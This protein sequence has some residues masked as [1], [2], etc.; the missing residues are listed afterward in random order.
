MVQRWV[1]LLVLALPMRVTF[2]QGYAPDEA[3]KR[4]AVADGLEVTL[5]AAE[6]MVRQPV[7]IEFDDRGRLWVI[8]YLQYPN[9][10]G[11]SRVNVD[12]YSRTTYDKVPPPPP[13]GPKGEDRVTILEDVNGDGRADRATDFV[14]GLNLASG[15]AFG[16]GGVF[17]LNAPYLLFYPDRDRND[18]PDS[19]PEVLLTGFGMEDAHSVA[20][21]LAWGP[22]GWLYGCQ[23]STV[24]AN[25]RGVE[26]QQGV[27][28]YHPVTRAF[29]LFCEGGGNSWGLDFDRHGNL[30]YNTNYGGYVMLHAVQGGYYW[31]SFGKHGPLHNPHAYGYIDHVPHANFTGGHVSVGGVIYEGDNLPAQYRGKFISPDLLDHS[32]HWHRFERL[33]SSFRSAHGGDLLRAN[34]TWFASSDMTMGPDGALYVADWSD[35]RTAHPDPDAEWDRSNGRI[36]RIS[37]KGRKFDAGPDYSKLSTDQLIALLPRTDNWVSRKARRELASRRDPNARGPLRDIV[38]RD[39]DDQLSLE[40]LWALCVSDPAVIDAAL[41]EFCLKHRNP[42]VRRWT[43]QLLG[44]PNVHADMAGALAELAERETDVTVRSQLASTAK[45]LPPDLGFRI[46]EQLLRR[47]L[48]ERDPHIPLLLWWAVEHHAMAVPERM[49]AYFTSADAWRMSLVRNSILDRLTRRFAAEGTADALTACA[50]LL[51]SAPSP[52]ERRRLLA[53]VDEG[54]S[55]NFPADD[56]PAALDAQ[57]NSLWSDDATDA[58]LLRLLARLRKPEALRRATALMRDADQP[59][60]LRLAMTDTVG[61]FG[62]QEAVS[63]LLAMVSRANES[64][65]V[66]S[67]ALAALQRFDD[68]RVAPAVLAAYPSFPPAVRARAVDALLSRRESAVALLD[69]V[70]GGTIPAKDVT[71]DQLRQAAAHGDKALDARVAKRWGKVTGGTPEEKLAQVRRLNNDLRAAAGDPIAGREVFSNTCGSC[72]KLF[73][74]GGSVGPDLTHANRAD[75]DYLLVSIVDPSSVVRAEHLSHLVRTTDGRVLSGLLVEQT[76]ARITLMDAKGERVTVPREK[77]Q[78]VKESPVSLMPEGLLSGMKPQ[79]LRDLFGYLQSNGK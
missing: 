11:L 4:M 29:E 55:D 34:D 71:I 75:R 15:L 66:R 43:V 65:A 62:G 54:L 72:H 45:R 60:A 27:W 57:L 32:V 5:V 3:A 77:V 69:A 26:F 64:E 51:Q 52:A 12:R 47:N 19:D 48:D 13:R 8:Q 2:A 38:R 74:E 17:V 22:D 46:V 78:T 61:R 42:D 59:T 39:E 79:Q 44:D 23:G 33:G 6:P 20:N 30:L 1:W 28:R 35:K 24:T 21:S 56:L 36:Y 73:D 40:A 63:A 58:T 25:I 7:C 10:A 50:R 18:V 76:P 70:D 49:L 53:A 37:A 14:S 16:H 67:A 31:K 68:A 9:P 41:A